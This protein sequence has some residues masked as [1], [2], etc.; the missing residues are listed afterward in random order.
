M[1]SLSA[2]NGKTEADHIKEHAE[3][4]GAPVH[5]FDPDASPSEK[6]AAAGKSRDK[7]QSVIPKD[8]YERG[9]CSQSQTRGH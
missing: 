8:D 9:G 2:S 3:A 6:A 7:L 4:K 1:A 5:S